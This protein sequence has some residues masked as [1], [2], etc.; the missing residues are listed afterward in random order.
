MGWH[1]IS[2]WSVE[3]R[4]DIFDNLRLIFMEERTKIII[5]L[6]ALLM[7]SINF[8]Y[9]IQQSGKNYEILKSCN[10]A[11]ISPT[12]YYKCIKNYSIDLPNPYGNIS[13]NYTKTY[14]D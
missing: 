8:F 11:K 4:S 13:F 10:D 3:K 1:Y 14:K 6:V 9:A 2:L 5:A 12:C 7:M